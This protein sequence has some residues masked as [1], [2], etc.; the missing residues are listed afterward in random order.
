M[1]N[2]ERKRSPQPRKSTTADTKRAAE[3]KDG[4]RKTPSKL[5]PK[6]EKRESKVIPSSYCDIQIDK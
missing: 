2:I 1:F 3:I 4:K 5:S 6:T